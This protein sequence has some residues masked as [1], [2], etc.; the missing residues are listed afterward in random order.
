MMDKFV[1]EDVREFCLCNLNDPPPFK[2]YTTTDCSYIPI[3]HRVF[4][5]KILKCNKILNLLDCNLDI[6]ELKNKI[7]VE[8]LFG[9]LQNLYMKN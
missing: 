7:S 1:L 6:E 5:W 9:I 4:I 2:K 3:S 8:K